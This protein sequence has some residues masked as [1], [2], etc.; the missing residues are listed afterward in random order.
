[1]PPRRKTNHVKSEPSDKSSLSDYSSEA[2]SSGSEPEITLNILERE[3]R[4]TAGMMRIPNHL[5]VMSGMRAKLLTGEEEQKDRTFWGSEEHNT[6]EES[7]SDSDISY[8]LDEL[9]EESESD[10]ELDEED[11]SEEE[12]PEDDEERRR[13]RPRFQA[14][15]VPE[16]GTPKRRTVVRRNSSSTPK[17]EEGIKDEVTTDTRERRE[18]TKARSLEVTE[19]KMSSSF[20]LRKKRSQTQYVALT[21]EQ[22]MEEA[23][24]VEEW[25]KADY[26]AYLR[27][28]EMSEKE[29]NALIQKR[30][31]NG[32]K[33]LYRIVSRSYIEDGQEKSELKL[34]PP[35]EEDS[36]KIKEKMSKGILY[37]SAK[38]VLRMDASKPLPANKSFKYRYPYGDME[39]YNTIAEY[40]D[41]IERERGKEV[42]ESEKLVQELYSFLE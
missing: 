11:E 3:K 39:G 33:N 36:L 6:W 29:R 7:E 21:Q 2:D 34:V 19:R 37:K 12:E 4:V 25:N 20:G 5:W 38:E 35:L 30:R 22:L 27:Y 10:S 14:Y 13:K 15:K 16:K 1:M 26:D 28:T 31:N 24:M 32:S 42:L 23:K 17:P 8:D 41:I 9:E 40:E 18:T